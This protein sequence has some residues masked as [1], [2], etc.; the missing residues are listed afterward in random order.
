MTFDIMNHPICF[1]YPERTTESAWTLHVPIA[2]LLIDLVRP[3]QF[4]ELGT[5]TGLSYCA[6]CQAVKELGT[7]TRCYAVDTWQGEEHSGLYG[8]EILIDLQ[9]HHDS[10]YHE[11]SRLIQS[12]FDDAV[13]EFADGSIDLLHIDGYHTYEAV[14]H[15]FNTW[16]PK[17]SSRGVVVLHDTNEHGRDFGVW[18]FWDELKQR[19]PHVEVLHGHGLG[20]V[21]VGTH[22]PDALL[23]LLELDGAHLAAAQQFF[24]EMGMR[25]ESRE[26]AKG[27]HAAL[28]QSKD[29]IENLRGHIAQLEA[30]VHDYPAILANA[31]EARNRAEEA[32]NRAVNHGSHLEDVVLRTQRTLDVTE[33]H[34]EELEHELAVWQQ[35]ANDAETTLAALR[36]S[37]TIRTI[38]IWWRLKN[39]RA[40]RRQRRA[41]RIT[42]SR[43]LYRAARMTLRQQG[44]IGLTRKSVRWLRGKRSS[45][46][47]Q[48]ASTSRYEQ[49]IAMHEPDAAGLEDQRRVARELA[50]QPLISVVMA[51]YNPPVNVLREA[52]QSVRDQTYDRWEL[53]IAN[54]GDNS[55]CKAALNE[56]A[57]RDS[58]IQVVQ[59]RKN[60]GI[61]ENSNVALG[62]ARG[63]FVALMD[64]D[65]TLAPCALYA[66]AEAL[67]EQPNLDILYSDEDRLTIQGKRTQPFMKP[68][69]SPELLHSFMYVGHLTVYRASLMNELGG[70]RKEFDGSQ[71][72]DLIHRAAEQ[73]N[74]VKHIQQ[75]LYHW[76]M[77]PTS[78]AAGAKADARNTNIAALESAMVR[79]GHQGEA[80]V[81]PYSNRFKFAFA[82]TPTVSIVIPTDDLHNISTCLDR[83]DQKTRYPAIEVVVVTNSAVADAIERERHVLNVRCA[84]Y[85]GPFNFSLKCNLGARAAQGQYLVFLNDDVEP[86]SEDW[87]ETLLEYARQP[88]IGGASPKLLYPE[89]SIQYAGLVTGVRDLVGTAF[90]KWDRYA[91]DYS[92]MAI[93]TRDVSTLCGA[94]MMVRADAFWRVGGWDDVNTPIANSDFDISFKLRDL[95][96]RLVYTPFAEMRHIGHQSIGKTE[97]NTET[98]EE[99]AG[100]PLYDVSHLYMLNRWGQYMSRDPYFPENMRAMVYHEDSR[101]AVYAPPQEPVR[102]WSSLRRILLVSHDL[103]LSGAPI[104]LFEIARYLQSAGY[105]VTVIAPEE[106]K[107]LA[108][109]QAE[110]IPVLIDPHI[111]DDP[112]G[113]KHLFGPFDVIVPNTVLGWRCV[114]QAHAIGKP[115]VWLVHESEFGLEHIRREPRQAR[116]AFA[117]ADTVIFPAELTTRLYRDFERANPHIAIH[118]GIGDVAQIQTPPTPFERTP[119]RLNL[120]HC[121]SVEP[122]KGQEVVIKSLKQ[123]PPELAENVHVYFVG[124]YHDPEYT[125]RVKKLAERMPNA[126]F[127]GEVSRAQV[128]SYMKHADVFV[129]TSREETGPIVVFEAM[130]LGKAVISTKV[131]AASEVITSGANGYLIEV[132]DSATL[133]R[134][135]AAL[136]QQPDQVTALGAAA[137]AT[138]EDSLTLDRYGSELLKVFASVMDR[139]VATIRQ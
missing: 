60:G 78:A 94:C 79:R 61:S 136:I 127:L 92:N 128:L 66:V 51:V 47:G 101:Y 87:I 91:S 134:T 105:Y 5:H 70:F 76:R 39:R 28:L 1:S 82:D 72:Y 23:S 44:P 83:L 102:D 32:R 40:S 124:R 85:D 24:F 122:R 15:D 89:N 18:Q 4:V 30:T 36:N 6:F 34:N 126:H 52:I 43:H 71:D 25:I 88:E 42:R 129:C 139:Q 7:D 19:Y 119:G 45:Y 12:T 110:R 84:R 29:D 56:F 38:S 103:T 50:Y 53:C 46:V 100:L 74:K 98:S 31:E 21:A 75:V 138:Y 95:G 9:A 93:S 8:A 22:V 58:R 96:L 80:I 3:A 97:K 10:R 118:Y 37:R 64:H 99:W 86:L 73:T 17:M 20:I 107:L 117:L 132:D 26:E 35:R 33:A 59:L 137:R 67:N 116:E 123:L 111:L 63:E 115:C 69:W 27:E 55:A 109:Y 49:W 2:M 81:Y 68:D 16:L 90:H 54:A 48:P 13:A 11:F 133:A 135:I 41:S 62:L 106:G 57:K 77:I 120:V 125:Q 112:S 131:G 65:D 14:S 104:I 108:E 130:A 121:G 113:S 114:R